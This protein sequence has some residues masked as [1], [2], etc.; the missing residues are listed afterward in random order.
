MGDRIPAIW[1]HKTK[2]VLISS[3]LDGKASYNKF[4]KGLPPVGEWTRIEVNQSMVSSQYIY[5]ISIGNEQVFTKPFTK[6]VELA[7]VKVYSGNPWSPGQQGFLRNLMIEVKTPVEDCV[8]AGQMHLQYLFKAKL[9]TFIV[10]RSME[11]CVFPQ[12]GT[13]DNKK[14]A[15]NHDSPFEE[16][17]EALLRLQGE[18]LERIATDLAPD[19]GRKRSGKWGQLRRP[20]SCHLDAFLQRL[21]RIVF[22]WRKIQLFQ[23][24]Q[25]STFGWGMDQHRGCSANGSIRNYLHHLHWRGTGLLHQKLK[26]LGL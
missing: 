7:D 15:F 6:P 20:D 17:M 11:H 2:G 21:P 4:F 12:R 9:L 1:F 24:L 23:L 3:G 13:P 14:P 26:T 22:C 10:G 18:Q 19:G 16:G 8:K 5:S 25:D